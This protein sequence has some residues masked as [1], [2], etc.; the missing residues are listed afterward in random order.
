[1]KR[2]GKE[3]LPLGHLCRIAGSHAPKQWRLTPVHALE[4]GRVA[5]LDAEKCC[6]RVHVIALKEGC[7]AP[8]LVPV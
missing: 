5:W 2:E 3:I 4:L 7:A 8:G 1:M 6:C